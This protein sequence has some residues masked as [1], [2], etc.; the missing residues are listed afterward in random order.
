MQGTLT[1]SRSTAGHLAVSEHGPQLSV[2]AALALTGA[3]AGGMPGV[4]LGFLALMIFI[5][6]VVP[7]PGRTA[8]E[9][10]DRFRRLS[11]RRRRADRV[12]ALRR[13]PPERLDVLDDRAGWAAT[14]DRRVLGVQTIDVGSVTGTVEVLKARTFDRALR[15]DASDREQWKRVWLAQAH[16]A[17]LP[18][19]SVYR[20]GAEHVIRDGHH[21]LSVARDRGSWTIDADVVELRRTIS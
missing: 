15:P 14:A 12:R 5:D 17:D 2:C 13:R 8:S 16:G 11:R 21:R 9:A 4:L 6:A 19:I 18:P 3:V 20:V 10:D 7:M 1:A